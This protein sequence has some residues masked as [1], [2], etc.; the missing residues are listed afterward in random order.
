M[1][2]KEKEKS[3]EINFKHEL[4]DNSNSILDHI[5]NEIICPITYEPADQLCTLECQ[6]VISLNNLKKLK[7]AKCPI[8]QQK[9]VNVNVRYLP[10]NT[11]YKNLYSR[12]FETGHILPSI[13]TENQYNSN[14]DES[15]DDMILIKKN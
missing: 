8:C 12:F 4:I 1:M 14:S 9:I 11:I 10:Q 5:A 6:H 13:E 7:Q 2:T 3:S 15:E